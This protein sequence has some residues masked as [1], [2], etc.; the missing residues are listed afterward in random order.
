MSATLLQLKAIGHQD[1][2]LTGNPEISFFRKVYKRHTNFAIESSEI[3]SRT[4]S[5]TSSHN[6]KFDV[7]RYGDLLSNL[8]LEVTLP[9]IS[10]TTGTYL[11]WTNNTAH[12]YI[13]ECKINI[14]ET[15]DKHNSVWLDIWNELTDSNMLQYS[16]LNKHLCKKAYLKSGD[17]SDTNKQLKLYIPLQF[18]FCKNVGMA[19]P[20]ISLQHT[21]IWVDVTVRSINSILN[22]DSSTAVTITGTPTVKLYGDY[23]FLDE[24]ERKR[25]AQTPEINYLI[26]QVQYIKINPANDFKL[27]FTKPVKTL[28]WV[29]RNRTSSKDSSI[30][31]SS[32][33]DAT[34]NE[35][36]SMNHNNDYFNYMATST[37]I[38]EIFNGT[39]T[40]EPFSNCKIK[41][42]NTDRF[43]YRPATYFRTIQPFN[44]GFNVPNKHIYLYSFALDAK[45]SDPTGS[46]NFSKVD[47]V[48]INF[49]SVSGT[50]SDSSIELFAVNYNILRIKA[51]MAGLLN[52]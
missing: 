32:I 52:N 8:V 30:A 20:L 22:T 2:F 28:V 41:L 25:F 15:I 31:S 7:L 42:N 33:K 14:G 12:A 27:N 1:S 13:K 9:K 39:T 35:P 6:I 17:I 19:L 47:N 40:Y 18:W 48:N 24:N 26:E 3:V 36:G 46:L 29:F 37:S 45:D 49:E 43:A 5:S 16:N 23:I 10:T 51:G 4:L 50:S 38:S 11:N 44:A 21:K 34:K